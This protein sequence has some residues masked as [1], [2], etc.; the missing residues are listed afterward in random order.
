M[1]DLVFLIVFV[2]LTHQVASAVRR[3]SD[4][5]LEF[6]QSRLLA[7]AALLFPFGPF[8]WFIIPR[9]GMPFWVGSVGMFLCYVPAIVLARRASNAFDTAGTDRVKR[10]QEATSK[11]KLAALL[12]FIY[13]AIISIYTIVIR[14]Y[15]TQS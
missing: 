14:S 8:V 5:F 15:A 6:K 11:A 2:V 10:A 1:L 3:E 12:G 7:V 13:M 9:L 4:I